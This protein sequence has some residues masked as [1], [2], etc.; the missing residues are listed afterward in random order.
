MSN[1]NAKKKKIRGGH[2]A[3]V[4]K[5]YGQ[6]DPILKDYDMEKESK[7]LG[8]RD[9]LKRKAEILAQLDDEILIETDDAEIDEM[10]D[11]NE[12]VQLQIQEKITE[13]DVLLRRSHEKAK[14]IAT[15][16]V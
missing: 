11:T 5:L 10:I 16:S 15:K 9:T 4:Q 7:L 14:E 2:K 1:T 6:I 13:I 8:L 12:E 3:H